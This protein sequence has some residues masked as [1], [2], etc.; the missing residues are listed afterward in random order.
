MLVIR[1]ATEEDFDALWPIFHEIAAA[2]EIYG[3]PR[4]ISKVEAERG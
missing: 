3:Y 4:D 2:G 1:E